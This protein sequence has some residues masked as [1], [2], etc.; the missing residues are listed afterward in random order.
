MHSYKQQQSSFLYY[1][2]LFIFSNL[3]L[4]FYFVGISTRIIL[5][6]GGI[7]IVLINYNFFFYVLKKSKDLFSKNKLLKFAWAI[8]FISV[9]LWRLR[10]SKDLMANPVDTTAFLRM[11]EVAVAGLIAV[12]MLMT[13]P[14]ISALM[15]PVG[16]MLMYSLSGIISGVYS[17]YPLYA[18]YKA[19]E[20]TAGVVLITAI[21]G[22]CE[23]FDSIKEFVQL[24]IAL[25]GLLIVL[26]WVGALL[27]PALAFSG[28]KGILSVKLFGVMPVINPNAVGFIGALL[29]LV[30]FCQMN[31]KLATK[32]KIFWR[33]LLIVSLIT[34]VIAQSRT[35]LIGFV[36]AIGVW[37]LLN[38]KMKILF[39]I[40]LLA[41]IILFNIAASEI[42]VD[43]FKRGSSDEMLYTLTGRTTAWGHAW[44]MFK[45]SP[46]LGYGFAS[47]A[48]FD[49]LQGQGMV[50]MHGSIF[51]V[52]VNVGLLGLIPWLMA[53]IIGWIQLVGTFLRFSHIMNPTVKM[54]HSLM[55]SIMLLISFRAMTG[56]TIVMHDKEFLLLLVV[57][58]YAQL[59]AKL[60]GFS[61]QSEN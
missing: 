57:L 43:Y 6:F 24:N 4:L 2:A 8:L 17:S 36:V 49:V 1:I 56:T 50:G 33:N 32:E 47:G 25:F 59:G 34:L 12:F 37:L 31:K 26:V 30:A 11:V 55:I 58:A 21:L 41:L 18:A 44:R 54:F 40:S 10:T 22:R 5:I 3:V 46:L 51:D 52:I 27:W 16:L 45:Q 23:D 39:F 29:A 42:L 20:T 14:N 13:K 38:R 28:S 19:L 53:L 60:K 9:F 61:T 7:S 35:S 15:G 48:R